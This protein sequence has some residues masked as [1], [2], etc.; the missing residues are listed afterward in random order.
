MFVVKAGFFLIIL[1]FY[2]FSITDLGS[3]LGCYDLYTSVRTESLS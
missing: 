2:G 3:L 1:A